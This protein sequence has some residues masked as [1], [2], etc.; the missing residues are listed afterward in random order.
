MPRDEEFSKAASTNDFDNYGNEEAADYIKKHG[1]NSMDDFY[2][3]GFYGEEDDSQLSKK[4]LRRREKEQKRLEKEKAKEAKI[5]AK[6]DAD[7][8]N[9]SSEDADDEREY[10]GGKGRL[11]LKIELVMILNTV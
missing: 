3:D 8:D 4:E 9:V 11:A 10:R 6:R 5:L 1:K 7:F 2:G